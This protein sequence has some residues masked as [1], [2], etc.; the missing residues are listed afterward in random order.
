MG[1][2]GS[3]LF[4]VVEGPEG[5]GKS[6][7][8]RSLAARLHADGHPVVP[9]REPGGA[10]VAEAARTAV[11]QSPHAITPAAEL[12]LVLTA[13][14]QLVQFVVLSARGAGDGAVR[15]P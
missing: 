6:T 5:A 2:G 4:V 1:F 8:V 7:L 14:T 10:P 12:F 11:L 3:G 15:C 13:P 9:V